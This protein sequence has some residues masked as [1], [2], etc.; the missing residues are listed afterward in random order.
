METARAPEA[1]AKKCWRCGRRAIRG[2]KY[3]FYCRQAVLHEMATSGYLQ[4]VPPPTRREGGG[5]SKPIGLVRARKL[6]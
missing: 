3:C 6:G 5:G 1:A 4:P 2:E